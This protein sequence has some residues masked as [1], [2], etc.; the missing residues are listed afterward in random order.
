MLFWKRKRQEE[1]WTF[2]SEKIATI[3]VDELKFILE[4]AEKRYKDA[5]E[6]MHYL[7]IRTSFVITATV[8]LTVMLVNYWTSNL[9]NISTY[10]DLFVCL[11]LFPLLILCYIIPLSRLIFSYKM[12]SFNYLGS[13]PRVQSGRLKE[14]NTTNGLATLLIKEI[15]EYDQKI[16]S[17]WALY[18]KKFTDFNRSVGSIYSAI[19]LSILFLIT[20]SIAQNGNRLIASINQIIRENARIDSIKA[21]QSNAHS[22]AKPR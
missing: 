14:E 4:Q 19:I 2:P 18:D 1:V 5:K 21:A 11:L 7:L 20:F 22:S 15:E 9:K 16:K 12:S 10:L 13:S 8:A 3:S 17:H 6:S